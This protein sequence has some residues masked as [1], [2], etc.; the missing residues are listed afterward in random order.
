MLPSL[1]CSRRGVADHLVLCAVPVRQDRPRSEGW[2]CFP[3]RPIDYEVC[4]HTSPAG[5]SLAPSASSEARAGF[6]ESG[7][8]ETPYTPEFARDVETTPSAA[9]LRVSGLPAAWDRRDAPPDRHHDD[10]RHTRSPRDPSRTPD[11]PELCQ[12]CPNAKEESL[13]QLSKSSC[14][15]DDSRKAGDETRTR[16]PKLGK[17]V[18]YQLSYTRIGFKLS[19][20]AF[21]PRRRDRATC[22]CW[23]LPNFPIMTTRNSS[24][25][26]RALTRSRELST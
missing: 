15:P 6:A 1:C 20:A 18:L 17:L 19:D 13:P 9:R 4:C 12:S 23:M 3:P 10:R 16:D 5:K 8:C 14:F 7:G 2:P 11:V 21:T 25:Q 22:G 26:P 24:D